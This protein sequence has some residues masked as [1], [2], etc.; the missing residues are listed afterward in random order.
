MRKK[1]GYV[2]ILTNYRKTTLYIGVTSDLEQ[3]LQQ[4][5]HHKYPNSFTAK[6]KCVFLVYFETFDR[7]AA[8]IRREKILKEWPRVRKENLIRKQN[9]AFLFYDPITLLLTGNGKG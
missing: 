4:H 1:G 3:R 9:P 8:A 6:Y 5:I 2:Y 7:M